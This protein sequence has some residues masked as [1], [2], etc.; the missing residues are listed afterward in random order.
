MGLKTNIVPNGE[1]KEVEE[2]FAHSSI[3]DFREFFPVEMAKLATDTFGKQ[4]FFYAAK[5]NDLLVG[6]MHFSIQGGVGQLA[7]IQTKKDIDEAQQEKIRHNLFQQFLK[8]CNENNCHLA[9]MWIPYQYR[10][11]ITT[12]LKQGFKK[13]LTARNFWYKNDF[14]LLTKEL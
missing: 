8:I 13:I 7:A 14:L 1:V 6:A 5:N 4:E 9:F 10:N 3:S 12:Y 2:F 11:T